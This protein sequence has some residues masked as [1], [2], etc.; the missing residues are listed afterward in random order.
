MRLFEWKQTR[1]T[2]TR[3][4]YTNFI[5]SQNIMS[6]YFINT[7]TWTLFLGLFYGIFKLQP[8]VS[9]YH[10]FLSCFDNFLKKAGKCGL[11]RFYRLMPWKSDHQKWMPHKPYDVKTHQ[12]QLNQ[13]EETNYC[14]GELWAKNRIFH[15]RHWF[16]I[17][18]NR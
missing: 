15:N 12:M 7:K 14:V 6:C 3:E 5:T 8:K 2:S 18:E 4:I 17:I 13:K 10:T 1:T 11:W 9:K 16:E